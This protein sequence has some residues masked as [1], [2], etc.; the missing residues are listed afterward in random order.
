MLNEK[1]I[2]SP[3]AIDINDYDYHLPEERIAKF[4]LAE[5]DASKLLVY[6]EGGIGHASFRELPEE[7]PQG[8]LLLFNNTRVIHARLPF[9][10]ETGAR[11]EIFC[12]EPISPGEHQQS[13]SATGP[14]IWKC[15]IGN[16][17][18]WK[19]EELA[20]DIDTPGGNVRLFAQRQEAI[21]DAWS[22]RFRWE[23]PTL[24]FGE[25][26]HYAG[27]IP[28]PPYLHRKNTPDDEHRY[29][30]VYARRE[31]SVAAPTAGLHF[32][33]SL[34]ARLIENGI[35]SR[36]V[37]LHVGA[38]TFKP[39]K[40]ERLADHHMHSEKISVGRPVIEALL[41]AAREDR[42]IIPV[43]TTSLRTLE[44][45]F[46]YGLKLTLNPTATPQ[47]DV[48]QWDPYELPGHTSPTEAL[49][50][51][52][53]QLD[54]HELDQLEGHTQLMIAPGYQFRLTDGLITN[55]HQPR[56]TLL[57]LIAALVG[58]DWRGIYEYALANDFRFLSYGDG[59]LLLK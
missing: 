20:L 12:L 55:F 5:R 37:T 6:R 30:T 26:L 25:L 29:Q 54:R 18:R 36:F 39:V 32:T 44:S 58:N 8:A 50:A 3:G 34:L 59:S 46:W 48:A 42:P 17:K 1:T 51:I 22:V 16:N 9:R 35:S 14:V 13:L 38:G 47:L 45:L 31:G 53:D 56:S 21:E 57:L 4:P 33:E 49:T 23:G 19:N 40:A 27:L 52:L 11:I 28:L 7:L 2:P 24:A 15:L 10:R 43:G 41:A